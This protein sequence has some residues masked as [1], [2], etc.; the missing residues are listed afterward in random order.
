MVTRPD[1]AINKCGSVGQKITLRT[2]YFR[3]NKKPEWNIFQYRVDFE[4]NV[5]LKRTR[6]SLVRELKEMFQGA[7]LFDGSTLFLTIKLPEDPA[8]RTVKGENDE[9]VNVTI[10]FTT[11]VS[12]LEEQAMQ[13][14]NIIM[15][16]SMDGLKLQTVGR[17]K[18]DADEKVSGFSKFFEFHFETFFYF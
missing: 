10:K 15:R 14:L 3:L 13:I 18:F 5:E 7:Y 1:H 6:Y 8:V 12:M 17:N 2:N 11:V 9:A 4:P 16:K